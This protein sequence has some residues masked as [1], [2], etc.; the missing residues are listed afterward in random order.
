MRF[1]APFFFEYQLLGAVLLQ[2]SPGLPILGGW[3]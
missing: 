1:Q 2:G 3:F